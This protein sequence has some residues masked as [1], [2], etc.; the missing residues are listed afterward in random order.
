MGF[1]ITP[2]ELKKS[3][4]QYRKELLVMMSIGLANSLQ[5]MTLRPG[6]QYKQ[7][8]GQYD[9]NAQFGP[10]DPTRKNTTLWLHRCLIQFTNI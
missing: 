3:A 10:Y 5:H 9:P 1:T 7:K 4:I 6:V 2:D 8:V